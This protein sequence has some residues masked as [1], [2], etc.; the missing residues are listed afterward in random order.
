MQTNASNTDNGGKGSSGL[1]RDLISSFRRGTN[2]S[3]TGCIVCKVRRVKCDETKPHCIRCTSTGRTCEGYGKA[4]E[5][6]KSKS[7]LK[8]PS[9]ETPLLMP[10]PRIRYSPSTDVQASVEERRSFHYFRSRNMSEMPGNFEPYFWDHIVLQF[11]HKYPTILQ[12]LVALSAIY[13]E[14][15]QGTPGPVSKSA[16]SYALQQYNKAVKDL[17]GYLGSE[18]QDMKVALTACLIFVWIEFLQDDLNSGFQHLSCGLKILRDCIGIQ[19]RDSEDIFGSL[20]RSFTRL[21]IQAAVHG[22]QESQFTTT[23]TRELEILEPIPHSFSNVFESRNVLD[24][25][26]NAIFGYI[27][28][29]QE[30]DYYAGV[31]M[32]IFVDIRRGHLERLEQWHIATMHLVASLESKN[33][34]SQA[35][36]ILYLQLY[37]T[38]VNIIW[39][40]EF[41]GSE[42]VFDAYTAEFE[43]MTTI[44]SSLM[45]NPNCTTPRVLSF[46]MGIIPPLF[47]LCVKCRILRIRR[48]A[49]ALLKRAPEREGIW[50]RDSMVR[51]SEWKTMT[52]EQWRDGLSED[53]PLPEFGRIYAEHIPQTGEPSMPG[54]EGQPIRISFKRGPVGLD[55]QD[56]IE[57]P[58]GSEMLRHMGNML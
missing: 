44:A 39:K 53:E 17:M 50:H 21:R 33:D 29:L 36:G 14:H 32:S 55:I 1:P 11:S 27:R 34:Q 58:D 46:D 47:L 41:A 10:R 49:I 56:T 28:A 5:R 54:S 18:G 12:A 42:M 30:A 6:R 9:G 35:S 37:Y 13:E 16:D 31:D 19:D 57:I 8:S 25:E 38:M 4:P 51:Y 7:P 52:E 15:E 26:L 23:T 22:A 40:A 20:D 2:K 3:K 45:D 48:Q 24:K 43:T